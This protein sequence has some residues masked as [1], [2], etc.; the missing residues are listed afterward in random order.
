MTRIT[1]AALLLSTLTIGAPAHAANGCQK[2]ATGLPGSGG[3]ACRYTAA[4]PG[5]FAVA[6]ASGFRVQYLRPG[7]EQWVTVAAQ[8]AIPNQPH[9]GV[10]V[11]T[12]EIPSIAGDLVEVSI[13]TAQ[14]TEPNTGQT[15]RWMDGVIAGND[16]GP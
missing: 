14:V 6:T 4:G 1:V 12:G 8:V 5:V 16:L 7:A 9:T 15:L 13:G 2:I 10:A 11:R 3:G